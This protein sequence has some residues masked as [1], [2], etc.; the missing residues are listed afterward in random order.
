MNPQWIWT[1]RENSVQGFL[2]LMM[3]VETYRISGRV[4]LLTQKPQRGTRE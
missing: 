1:E 4:V 3:V 2:G